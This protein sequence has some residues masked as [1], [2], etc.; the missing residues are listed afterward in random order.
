[1]FF[2]CLL[3]I[4]LSLRL[5]SLVLVLF[6]SKLCVVVTCLNMVGIVQ[7]WL[8]DYLAVAGCTKSLL[9]HCMCIVSVPL[10]MLIGVDS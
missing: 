7:M 2:V 10:M 6:S 5:T 3:A 9:G 8:F 1:M 4:E